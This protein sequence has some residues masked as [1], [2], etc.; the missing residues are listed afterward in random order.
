MKKISPILQAM[1]NA[2]L[3]SGNLVIKNFKTKQNI[4]LKNSHHDLVTETD[5]QSQSLIVEE[6][7]KTLSRLGIKEAEIGFIGEENLVKHS[8]KY[9]FAIDPI[10]GTTNFASGI[11]YFAISISCFEDKK[12][13]YGVML[14]PV[15]NTFYF[16][17]KGKG[18]WKKSGTML[19]PVNVTE[20]ELKDAILVTFLSGKQKFLPAILE[21]VRLVSPHLRGTR[22]MGA[23]VQDF[24]YLLDNSFQICHYQESFI[25][26]IAAAKLIIEEAGG[27][28]VN[29]D[30]SE[31]RFDLQNPQHSYATMAGHP[32]VL[33]EFVNVLQKDYK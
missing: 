2:T 9:L 28:L 15:S 22:I 32:D 29:H 21:L 5:K 6:I 11:G 14:N 8:N 19:V 17:E 12:L 7:T 1:L 23:G 25:W 4:T 13:K 18:A 30:L 20:K 26:D 27:I 33:K 31:V 3:L 16:A 24:M 10:D